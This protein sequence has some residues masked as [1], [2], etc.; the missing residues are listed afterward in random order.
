[1]RG[2]EI[3]AKAL[4]KVQVVHHHMRGLESQHLASYNELLVH[5]HMRGLENL[6]RIGNR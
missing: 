4:T 5:H 3:Q 6:L 1:M 2:L